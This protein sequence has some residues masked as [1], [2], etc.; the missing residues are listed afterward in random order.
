M[1]TQD[2]YLNMQIPILNAQDII[3]LIF[4]ALNPP[5]NCILCHYRQ[6]LFPSCIRQC[7]NIHSQ[8][9]VEECLVAPYS[10]EKVAVILCWKIQCYQSQSMTL[11]WYYDCLK[12]SS[13]KVDFWFTQQ[14]SVR[15]EIH[16]FW[17]W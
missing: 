8:E 14:L 7:C 15:L 16:T 9:S 4:C 5:I 1:E 10:G 11:V 12:L 6:T 2:Q 3:S 17:I 13:N